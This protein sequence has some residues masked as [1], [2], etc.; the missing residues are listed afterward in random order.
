MQLNRIITILL[1]ISAI[2]IQVLAKAQPNTQDGRPLVVGHVITL[3]S[4]VLGEDRDIWIHV[5]EKMDT[6]QRY[7]VIYLLDAPSHFY[8]ATGILKLTSEWNMPKSILVGIANTDRVRDFT[9]TN[10]PFHRGHASETSGGAAPFLTFL[11]TEL[12]PYIQSHFP[13]EN[14]ATLVGHS[15]GGLFATFV[16]LHHPRA[17]DNYLALDPSLWW[18]K[19]VM[20]K[21]A[22]ELLAAGNQQ[23]QSLYLAVANSVGIDTVTV[24]RKKSEATAHLRANLAFHDVLVAHGAKLQY[25]WEYFGQEDHGSM[26]IPGIYNG[27]RQLFTWYPF[28]EMWRFNT[29]KQ[30]SIKEMIAPYLRHYAEL[31]R[32]FKREVKPDWQ[33]VND[34]A[35][36]MLT[37]HNLPKKALAFLQMNEHFYPNESRTYVALGDYYAQRKKKRDAIRHYEKAI[38]LDGNTE[39]EEKLAALTR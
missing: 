20:V 8:T 38:A 1:V 2:G 31:S 25:N 37:G 23:D 15:L 5:P 29:P 36:F 27:F 39:A 33:L 22:P 7:P 19:E 12:Q 18:D 35:F 14:M 26:Y 16:Y 4:E 30:Y 3:P 32:R 9:P 34:V 13:A 21:E 6:T 11:Q 10:V 28:P 17:F 24:R